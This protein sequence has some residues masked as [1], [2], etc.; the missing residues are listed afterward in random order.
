MRYVLYSGSL[1]PHKNVIVL[2]RAMRA[3][4]AAQ[5]D[6]MLVLTGAARVP[7]GDATAEE[8]RRTLTDMQGEGIA[9]ATGHL[10]TEQLQ[11]L[12]RGAAA[13]VLPSLYEGFG[14]PALEAMAAGC[15]TIGAA[16]SSIP[17]VVGDA[18]LLFPPRDHDDL[19][20]KLLRVLSEP[21]LAA[22]LS[23]TGRE[24]ATHFTWQRTARETVEVYREAAEL[25]AARGGRA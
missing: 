16:T 25:T 10:A 2:A 17:E 24:R 1:L 8:L 20:R 4:R 21:E 9:R 15:P 22:R 19:A 7:P 12:Y 14:F 3:V 6:V 18:G 23:L 13:F 11:A 5:P